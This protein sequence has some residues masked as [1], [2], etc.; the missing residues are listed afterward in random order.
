MIDLSTVGETQLNIEAVVNGIEDI[1]RVQF[2]FNGRSGIRNERFFPYALFGDRRGD[3]IPMLLGTG[4]QT[5]T[6]RVFTGDT[7]VASRTI[8]F[9]VRE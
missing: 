1:T 2:D 8:R 6:A 5:L 9:G 3:Y 7:E 4:S